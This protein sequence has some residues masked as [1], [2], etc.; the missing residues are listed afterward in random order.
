MHNIC[1]HKHIKCRH[2]VDLRLCICHICIIHVSACSSVGTVSC[3]NT[4]QWYVY[5]QL[6]SRLY[7]HMIS[8]MTYTHVHVH[9][10]F[11][12]LTCNMHVYS[13]STRIVHVNIYTETFTRKH[14]NTYMHIHDCMHSYTAKVQVHT[15]TCNVNT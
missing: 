7:Y 14:V 12:D 1:M 3:Y 9:A 6:F 8:I 5:T 15:C 11:V 2:T 4:K 13:T 10:H